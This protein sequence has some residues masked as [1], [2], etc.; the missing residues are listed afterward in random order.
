MPTQPESESA[1]AK[2]ENPMVEMIMMMAILDP[3]HMVA[4][5]QKMIPFATAIPDLD[6]ARVTEI[7]EKNF[8][9][10]ANASTNIQRMV[11]ETATQEYRMLQECVTKTLQHISCAGAPTG[12]AAKQTEVI[13]HL[14]DK[15]S[16]E[17]IDLMQRNS[18]NTVAIINDMRGRYIDAMEE[19]IQAIQSHST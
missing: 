12:T 3:H 1:L 16:K 2:S 5:M 14:I 17:T 15:L 13:G 6:A 18:E 11:S 10:I 8:W 9:A 4:A 7:Q 19:I